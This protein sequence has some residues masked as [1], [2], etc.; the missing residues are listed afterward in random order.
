MKSKSKLSVSNEFFNSKS[1][2]LFANKNSLPLIDVSKISNIT[3]DD[4]YD[5]SHTTP[6]GSEKIAQF[7]YPEVINFLNLTNE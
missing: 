5:D 7:I 3:R 6:S 2:I 1:F 4:F